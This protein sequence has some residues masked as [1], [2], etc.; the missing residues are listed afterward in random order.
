MSQS[1]SLARAAVAVANATMQASNTRFHHHP[2]SSSSSS[3]HQ[4]H[5]HHSIQQQ[6]AHFSYD[7][8]TAILTR[9]SATVAAA[10]TA[11]EAVAA[12]ADGA[13]PAAPQQLQPQ[14]QPY[15]F[16]YQQ[17]Q[18]QQQQ[19]HQPLYPQQHPM[20]SAAVL[21]ECDNVDDN[22]EP[23]HVDDDDYHRENTPRPRRYKSS[24]PVATLVRAVRTSFDIPSPRHDSQSLQLQPQHHQ[25]QQ[26]LPAFHRTS[27]LASLE[28]EEEESQPLAQV[29]VLPEHVHVDPLVS[30]NHDSD[31][32]GTKPLHNLIPALTG[33]EPTPV[34]TPPP[35]GPSTM[36][37][38]FAS[39]P[40]SNRNNHHP[41]NNEIYH[42][43]QRRQIYPR[44]DR[45]AGPADEPV[46]TA[47]ISSGRHLPPNAPAFRRGLR[48]LN[49]IFLKRRLRKQQQQQPQ[50][51][52]YASPPS[53]SS[54]WSPD[55]EPA[56]EDGTTSTTTTTTTTTTTLTDG[57]AR[58]TSHDSAVGSIS[59]SRANT[60]TRGC[61]HSVEAS[62]VGTTDDLTFPG[63]VT[64]NGVFLPPDL[65]MA[66]A[67][68]EYDQDDECDRKQDGRACPPSPVTVSQQQDEYKVDKSDIPDVESMLRRAAIE[69]QQEAE[70]DETSSREDDPI[71][72]RPVTVTVQLPSCSSASSSGDVVP[73]PLLAETARGPEV[74]ASVEVNDRL[75]VLFVG[76]SAEKSWLARA[77]RKG[78]TNSSRS[79]SS[80][81]R[82]RQ[83]RTLAV[84]V[85]TWQPGGDIAG[86]PPGS[87]SDDRPTIQ[88]ALWDVQGAA[89][90]I[91]GTPNF[92]GHPA[93]QSLFFS[94]RSLYILVWDLAASNPKTYWKSKGS[95]YGEEEDDED[96]DEDSDD[97]SDEEDG[98]N[99][100]VKEELMRQATRALNADLQSRVL[101]WVDCI[102]AHSRK[103]AILPVVVLPP[104]P[105]MSDHEV[106]QRCSMMQ[107]RLE[108]HISRM[109]RNDAVPHLLTGEDNIILPV[110]SSSGKGLDKVCASISVIASGSTPSV[111]DHV[112]TPIPP[113]TKLILDAIQRLKEDHKLILIDHL[114]F[115]VRPKVPVNKVMDALHFLAS[116]GEIIYFGTFHDEVLSRYIILSR[117]WFV[118][119]LSC[120]LRNSLESELAT[121]RPFMKMQC[122]YGNDDFPEC[123]M[124][125][126]LLSGMASSCPLLS[127]SDA[128]MLWMSKSF[129][130][131]A[132]NACSQS[133]LGCE[134]APSMFSFL[135]RLLVHSG[136][137][138]PVGQSN[139]VQAAGEV[140]F[141]PSLLPQVD[142]CDIW[143][144]RSSESWT[145]TLCHSWLFR[146]GSPSDLMENITCTV[147]KDLY[148][149]ARA[150]QGLDYDW[151][152]QRMRTLPDQRSSLNQFSC[153]E[154]V[155]QALGHVRIHQ[156][157]CWQSSI[158]V[159]VGTVFVDTE[160]SELR[161]SFSEIL[162]TVVDQRSDLCIASDAMRA[163]MHRVIVSGKGQVGHQGR[164]LWKGGYDTVVG[165]VRS[166][167]ERY[168]NVDAQVACPD[169][170]AQ[171]HPENASTWAWDDVLAVAESCSSQVRCMRRGHRV[172]CKLLCGA[173]NSLPLSVALPPSLASLKPVSQLLPSVV[174]IG[175]WDPHAKIMCNAGSGFIA[176]RKLGL[177]VTAGHT[178]FNMDDGCTFGM[179]YFGV[180]NAKVAIGVIPDGRDKAVFRY[181]GD[182]VAEDIRHVD[183]CIIQIKTRLECDV[184]DNGEGIA[185][186]PEIALAFPCQSETLNTLKM[187][188]RCEL[189]EAVRVLGFNQG[190]EGVLELGKHFN[191]SI[192][193]AK[194]YICKKFS[195]VADDS[196]NDSHHS[197]S[198]SSS[199]FTPREEI[200][201]I[202]PTIPGHSG[203]PCVNEEGK[204][205]GILSRADPC[206]RQRCYLVPAQE[207]KSLV[208]KAKEQCK[209]SMRSMVRNLN[210]EGG[211]STR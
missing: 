120:I 163:G 151:S 15:R 132:T 211:N 44:R 33:L 138:L 91:D 112:G 196:Q 186:Q 88:C 104:C 127:G 129:M 62:F 124:A 208:K 46:V 4:Y 142:P 147:L 153:N 67:Y 11:V 75:K 79:S 26:E 205:I 60:T 111:F 20:A 141:V 189:D 144:F 181:L 5:H 210:A 126:I 74:D 68:V 54:R 66:E 113:E 184:D 167:I 6:D 102:A 162:I 176:D 70:Q 72:F 148:A 161:E 145:T 165:S 83:S 195:V 171:C 154:N 89:N 175:L 185:D 50:K 43:T 40:R 8:A 35:T 128:K 123:D 178:L 134:S 73:L 71:Y 152:R 23:D 202:C 133:S 188:T 169:C 193:F 22:D 98:D 41:G 172:D 92:G 194:G 64:R 183:A 137:F 21:V 101:S 149:F 192:D 121:E 179:P 109:P 107:T 198:A 57:S 32:I 108:E 143:T 130:K 10:T 29:Q 1:T 157:Q 97:D 53:S 140:Y 30:A 36:S 197:E 136:V 160:S 42:H 14:P 56:E 131:E 25:E 38:P 114:L 166:V 155:E 125:K 204:V 39:L 200:V 9:A 84:D 95:A 13:P 116:I 170:I 47:A 118:S 105:K 174:V 117:K 34:P 187:T 61:I 82:K 110:E 77:L 209:Q 191:R 139:A 7:P 180:R 182:V 37:S 159:K 156:L 65:M 52:G 12:V 80:C 164:K 168:S 87:S 78:V 99:D 76:S 201:A 27:V 45:D 19:Q 28:E 58:S 150:F 173:C 135:E 158:L 146:S 49:K 93:T 177:V 3:S 106:K 90:F 85:H 69:S 100:F 24:Y 96:S 17:Q 199:S 18:Q 119:A 206:D 51:D 103:S 59:S 115:E 190:G 81:K 55:C 16:S 86:S 63:D 48:K 2:S 94:D 203:G 207:L 31:S 122:F